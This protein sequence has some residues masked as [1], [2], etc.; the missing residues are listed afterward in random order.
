MITDL[1][2]IAAGVTL[3]ALQTQSLLDPLDNRVLLC[4]ALGLSRVSLITQ[5]ERELDAEQAARFA[6]LVQRRLAGEPVAYIVGQR[7]FFGLPFEVNGAVLIPRPDT[8]LLVELTLDR[9][10]PQG[11]VLDMGTGSGAIAVALAHTRR[12]AAVTALDVSPDALA[13]AR[14]NA[15]ANGAQVNFL[16]SDWYTAL[17]GQPP[18]D[19][20]ASNPPYIASGDRHLSEGDLRYEPPG[21]LTDHADGLSALRIIVAGA[22]EHLKPQGWLLMEH[23]YDQAAAVRQ[24]LTDQ[25]YS[26]V[27]SW[28]DL[29]GIERVTGARAR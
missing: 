5:S 4:H 10:P 21:A 23:G 24:L 12:D 11:R 29:A 20:I 6:A 3:G 19:V 1:S 26:E 17:Q 7:E 2:A 13:V 22:A 28:T 16:Q 14:R 18:F 15:A 8:E 25:G 9:L 27:Q